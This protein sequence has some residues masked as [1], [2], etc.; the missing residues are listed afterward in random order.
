MPQR[1]TIFA[2]DNYYHVFNRGVE[3]RIIFHN[4]QDHQVFLDILTYYLKFV[5]KSPL[6]ILG[7]TALTQTGV[8]QKEITLVAYC[9]MPNHFH[10]LLKQKNKDS[11]TKF[12]QRIGTTYAL[13]FNK[14]YKRVGSLFQG[15]FK[16]KQL[17]TEPYL[18]QTTKYIHLNSTFT[19][20]GLVKY[21]WSSYRKFLNP[22]AESSQIESVT[23]PK[24]M[25]DYFSKTD[26]RLSYQSFV[27][28]TSLPDWY[29][30]ELKLF[31]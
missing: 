25:L 2:P 19:K 15:R 11:I 28:E 13:Y 5:K 22:Y 16:A 12:M 3:K 29:T 20:P 10:L 27:E 1:K 30:Q 6:N 24:S 18:L 21:P 31:A 9:L 4:K 17:D 8:F 26:P 7:R 23:Q 14:K